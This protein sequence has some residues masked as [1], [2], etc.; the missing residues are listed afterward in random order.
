[1]NTKLEEEN[2]E[3]SAVAQELAFEDVYL[4]TSPKVSVPD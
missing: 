3:A 1:M 2:E 4:F